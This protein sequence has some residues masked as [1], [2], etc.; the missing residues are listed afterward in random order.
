MTTVKVDE[1]TLDTWVDILIQKERVIGVQMRD[2]RFVYDDL[3]SSR[4]L[5]LDHDVTNLPPVKF[6][7]PQSEEILRVDENGQY[8]STTTDAPFILLG[9]HPYDVVAIR[10]LD[11]AF[12]SGKTD[13]HYRSRRQKASIIACD[14]QTP[15]KNIFAGRMG[16]ATVRDG[17]DILLTKVTN[18]YV[19]EAATDNGEALLTLM[20]TG[21]ATANEA[22]LKNRGNVWVENE[23]ALDQQ[24][25]LVDPKDWP[26]LLEASY[27][28]PIWD[29]KAELCFSCGA[30][31]L[32]CGTCTC[33]DMRDTVDWDLQQGTRTRVA[34]AC[35]ISGF[36]KVAGGHD[37]QNKRAA[38]YRHRF[39][40]KGS[41]MAKR[42]GFTACTGCG[43]C[44]G[45]CISDVANPVALYNKLYENHPDAIV[46]HDDHTQ[47]ANNATSP[48]SVFSLYELDK[49]LNVGEPSPRDPY[50]PELATLVRSY[51]VTKVETYY[52]FKLNSGRK[53]GHKPG[54]F[55]MISLMGFGEA[56][57]S[58][59]SSPS[60]EDSF[61]MVIRTV[62]TVTA[63]L[64]NLKPG[65][66]V[67]LRGPFG[68]S[69]PVYD[70]LKGKDIVVIVGGLGLV[71]VRSVIQHVLENRSDFGRLSIAYGMRSVADQLFSEEL[72]AWGKLPDVTVLQTVDVGSED[73]AGPVG[74]VTKVMPDIPL[75]PERTAAILCGPPV[76]YKFVLKE[77]MNMEVPKELIYASLER[78]MKCGVGK[79][80]HCQ[81]NNTYACQDG[82]VFL[83][84][85]LV[86]L[87]EAL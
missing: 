63:A 9:V 20:G 27:S 6:F 74:P 35:M 53:L 64:T 37:F 11:V 31:N 87:Q 72:E 23:S 29:E 69:F 12:M 15:S 77:L 48:I 19:V 78:K 32:V 85:D 5:R 65:D 25:L 40:R 47:T 79:C 50:L 68:T 1:S 38:R 46:Q 34:D 56:P 75:R 13:T 3:T 67:G 55:V 16:T 61:E 51:P 58:I 80:G 44:A 18:G 54:Q 59:T 60:K 41:Y 39:F 49:L 86:H 81:I 28:D 42:F 57:F 62:G 76:M 17:Y 21:V 45:A 4:D 30:C 52:E 2:N 26:A 84:S 70:T 10:Q 8:V 7:F 66:T 71:P 43:R 24:K 22:D 83:Y 82:P 36:M 33:F 73:W 14:V